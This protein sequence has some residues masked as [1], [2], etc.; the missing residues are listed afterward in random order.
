MRYADLSLYQHNNGVWYFED[1]ELAK[2]HKPKGANWQKLNTFANQHGLKE[3]KSNKHPCWIA[4]LPLEVQRTMRQKYTNDFWPKGQFVDLPH[5]HYWLF[6]KNRKYVYV[7]QPYDVSL[8]K[9]Q[10]VENAFQPLG[11]FVD[12]SYK[13]SW[14]WP[15]CTPLIVVSQFP[16]SLTKE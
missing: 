16:I 3:S 8:E 7:T 10:A 13:D 12:I 11:L 6:V 14:W 15:G 1:I 5:D 2:T 4:V 9:Y